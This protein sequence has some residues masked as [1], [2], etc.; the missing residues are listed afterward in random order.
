MKKYQNTSTYG[1]KIPYVTYNGF[2]FGSFYK[3]FGIELNSRKI[4]YIILLYKRNIFPN[5]TQVSRK[6]RT[7]L[8]YPQ[9]FLRSLGTVRSHRSKQEEKHYYE[10]VFKLYGI[11][12]LRRRNKPSEPCIEDWKNYDRMVMQH[13]IETVGCVMPYQKSETVTA[14]CEAG[15]KMKRAKSGLQRIGDELKHPPPCEGMDNIYSSYN[16]NIDTKK[17]NKDQFGIKIEVPT[18]L[19]EIR[20]SKAVDVQALIGNTGGYLGLFLGKCN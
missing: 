16:D 19:K 12:I 13:H 20:Q 11:E 3:C 6:F 4:N 14:M 10:M 8:H 15:G 7:F 18:G 17:G 2:Y 9:Q 5:G 1:R